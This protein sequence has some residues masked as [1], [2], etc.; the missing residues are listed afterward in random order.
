[1]NKKIAIII[2][3]ALLISALSFTAMA[4]PAGAYLKFSVDVNKP[5]GESLAYNYHIIAQNLGYVLADGDMLEY[6]VWLSIEET[7]WGHID[8]DI[9]GA[10]LRDRGFSDQDGT[11]FHT[12]QD[13]SFSAYNKWWRRSVQLGFSEDNAIDAGVDAGTEGKSLNSIQLSMHPSVSENN[14]SG[15][16]YYDNIVITNNGEVKLVIFKDEGDLDPDSFRLSHQKDSESTVEVLVFTAEEE[17][18][19]KDAEEARIREAEEREAARIA[20]AEERERER[21]ERE[22]QEQQSREEAE[23]LAAEEAENN[24]EPDNANT[25]APAESGG[26]IN[27]TLAAGIAMAGVIIAVILIIVVIKK[28]KSA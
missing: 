8:G 27:V 5:D 11:G 20:A 6:D 4:E 23:R 18:A 10:N 3:I 19:F 28:K 22:L 25:P 15:F 21:E 9:D 16:V 26:S 24:N 7:G 1:M 2:L 14:Y 17:Q 12:G 13:I